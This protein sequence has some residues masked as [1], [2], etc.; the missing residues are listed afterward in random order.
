MAGNRLQ[1]MIECA[2]TFFET[3]NDPAQLSITPE[4]MER[5]RRLHPCAMTEVADDQGPFVWI[6]V[7]PTSQQTMEDFLA[8]SIGER[9][10]LERTPPDVPCEALYLCSALV[11]PEFRGR[12]LATKAVCD[13]IAQIRRTHPIR[14]LY[15]WGFSPEGERLAATVARATGLPL[16]QRR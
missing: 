1:R 3:K 9:E 7:I 14:T 4:V 16:R 8:G 12:G 5:L 10:L 11:L 6:I 2:E 13:A 15:Y